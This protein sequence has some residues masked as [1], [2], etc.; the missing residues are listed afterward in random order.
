MRDEALA[1]WLALREPFDVASRSSA[2]ARQVIAALPGHEILRCVDLA[3]GTGSNIRYFLDRFS[4]RRQAWLGIDRSQAL[5]ELLPLRISAWAAARGHRTTVT[6]NACIVRGPESEWRIGT[7]Q[8]DL[9]RVPDADLLDAPHLIAASALLDLVSEA[10]LRALAAR[11]RELRCAALFT[12]TYNGRSWCSPRDPDDEL[13]LHLFNRH[14]RT[15]KGLGGRASGPNAVACAV[16]SFSDAGYVVRQEPSD[17]HVT[18]ADTA[19]QGQ[20][21]DGWAEAATETEPDAAASIVEWRERRMGHVEAGR[22]EL[23]VGHDDVGAW[24][25]PA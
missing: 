24:L 9:A 5:L 17:W 25:P 19:L 22:S 8:L 20:L 1:G 12:I 15:D 3:T 16:R 18:S 21:I 4:G 11:C 2:L 7:L 23:V 6:D 10:W 13:I 14:Q